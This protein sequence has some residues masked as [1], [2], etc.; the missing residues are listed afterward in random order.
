[1]YVC[2]HACTRADGG[3]HRR[4]YRCVHTMRTPFAPKYTCRIYAYSTSTPPH[5]TLCLS[6]TSSQGSNGRSRTG[7]FTVYIY[8]LRYLILSSYVYIYI[9]MYIYTYL[10]L[11]PRIQL[12]PRLFPFPPPRSLRRTFHKRYTCC[13][14]WC[15]KG[16]GVVGWGLGLDLGL[17]RG[18]E[19]R[20]EGGSK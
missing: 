17:R 3:M 15:R 7:V 12:H 20:Y 19:G 16:K 10:V 5:T 2:M 11:H 6:D 4:R 18:G 1:M 8:D 14:D 9:Y 13:S